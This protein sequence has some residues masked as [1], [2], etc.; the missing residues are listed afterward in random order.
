MINPWRHTE[1]YYEITNG[2]RYSNMISNKIN[3][4]KNKEKL[5]LSWFKHYNCLFKIEQEMLIL[6]FDSSQ[7]L[8]NISGKY[9][10]NN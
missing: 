6:N 7:Y 5:S 10:S 9:W 2:A 4:N 8:W 3:L 1:K